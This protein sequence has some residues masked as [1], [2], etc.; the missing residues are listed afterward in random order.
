MPRAWRQHPPPRSPPGES[1][2]RGARAPRRRGASHRRS[3]H[4]SS[5]AGSSITRMTCVCGAEQRQGCGTI[6][7]GRRVASAD[8][9]ARSWPPHPAT[10]TSCAASGPGDEGQ[11][12][13]QPDSE[14]RPT[15]L[16]ALPPA[17]LRAASR[18]PHPLEPG[19]ERKVDRATAPP[20]PRIARTAPG[21]L[22]AAGATAGRP[23]RRRRRPACTTSSGETSTTTRS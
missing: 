6:G 11:P 2:P 9:E 19:V 12:D 1:R 7:S 3:P 5:S 20:Q 13:G 18:C 16:R 4:L 21:A 17:S 23:A 10:A 14:R 8:D 15:L 22:H